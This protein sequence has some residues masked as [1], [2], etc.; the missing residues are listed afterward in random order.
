MIGGGLT[1][2]MVLPLS[3]TKSEV[4]TYLVSAG[5]WG[6]GLAWVGFL[7]FVVPDCGSAPSEELD[8]FL[9]LPEVGTVI[10]FSFWTNGVGWGWVLGVSSSV[11]N[12]R[13]W[14]FEFECLCNTQEVLW[15]ASFH[16]VVG[17]W[18]SLPPLQWFWTSPHHLC[19][20]LKR[21]GIVLWCL[22]EPHRLGWSMVLLLVIL[23]QMCCNTFWVSLGLP[24]WCSK[25]GPFLLV[26]TQ[27]HLRPSSHDCD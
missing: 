19:L 20:I 11:L 21:C 23:E 1:D 25:I 27:L 12:W 24:F 7:F 22:P 16:L 6:M 5:A 14:A 26:R 15:R 4:G 8:L 13:E 3:V 18:L 17:R 10:F 9:C 2:F